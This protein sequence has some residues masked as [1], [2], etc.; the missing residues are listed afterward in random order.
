MAGAAVFWDR[1]DTLIRD[2]GYI[3]DPGQVELLPGAADALKRLTAA[4]F[5][6]IIVTNQSGIARGLFDEPTLERIHDRMVG[7]FAAEGARIDAI[8]YCPYLAGEEA[9]V[10]QYRQDSELRKPKP[11]MVLQAALERKIDLAASWMIG[12]SLHDAQ[13]GKAA[14]CR[15]VIINDPDDPAPVRKGGDVDFIAGSVEEAAEIVLRYT[16]RSN[17]P[18]ATPRSAPA[19]GPDPAAATLQE[20]LAFLRT[21]D[22]RSRAEEFSLA[23]LAGSVLQIV[24][25]AALLWAVFGWLR[26]GTLDA[27]VRL[28]FAIVVQLMA[29]TSFILPSRK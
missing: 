3:S 26:G 21:V 17:P 29:L 4:G 8:Y 10:E 19:V 27:F 5:E 12:D 18:E 23:R 14:G 11:G 20:I 9:K 1:D 15:T 22:R 6:N 28:Q 16:R 24:A 13:A 25:V 2:P 7:L